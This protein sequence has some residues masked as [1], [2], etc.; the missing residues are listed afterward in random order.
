MGHHFPNTIIALAKAAARPEWLSTVL[1]YLYSL[2][3]SATQLMK[4]A[5]PFFW[6]EPLKFPSPCC[7]PSRMLEI[8]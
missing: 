2:I 3:P 1:I 7:V 4:P 5:T 8:G 6:T